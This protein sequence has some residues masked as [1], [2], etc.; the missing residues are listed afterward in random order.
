MCPVLLLFWE[1]VDSRWLVEFYGC[2]RSSRIYLWVSLRCSPTYCLGPNLTSTNLIVPEDYLVL[3]VLTLIAMEKVIFKGR[4]RGR[5]GVGRG[6]CDSVL[7]KGETKRTSN[8]LCH[9]AA[10]CWAGCAVLICCILMLFPFNA[11]KN[12]SDSLWFSAI[13]DEVL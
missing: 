10:S 2:K 13:Y 1:S 9:S 8:T 4:R 6:H 7:P 11:F 5:R 3:G 12:R